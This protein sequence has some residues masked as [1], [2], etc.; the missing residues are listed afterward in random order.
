M[1][2]LNSKFETAKS[3]YLKISRE[4]NSIWKTMHVKTL[5]VGVGV[6]VRDSFF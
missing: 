6:G 2:K 1:K 3:E 4:F 5:L